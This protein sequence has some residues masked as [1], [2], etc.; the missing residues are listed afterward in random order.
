MKSSE[1]VKIYEDTQSIVN[2]SDAL[3]NKTKQ[4]INR[5]KL[6]HEGFLATNHQPKSSA[7]NVVVKGIK[8]RLPSAFVL[9]A[10]E[11]VSSVESL[12]LLIATIII[13]R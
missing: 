13:L 2:S 4:S 6:Y 7:D 11:L 12:R 8:I 1:L 9:S 10:M 3:R 5:T